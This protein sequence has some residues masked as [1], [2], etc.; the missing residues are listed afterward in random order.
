[1]GESQNVGNKETKQAKFSV[2]QT[3]L[4]PHT[5]TYVCVSGG[6]KCLLY[7]KFGLLCFLVTSIFRFA[8]LPY[9]RR[10]D[11]FTVSF[12]NNSKANQNKHTILLQLHQVQWTCI[13]TTRPKNMKKQES[14][15]TLYVFSYWIFNTQVW[16]VFRKFSANFCGEGE[17]YFVVNK[18]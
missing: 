8:L 5:H 7:G 2:K 18:S 1:M 17:S 10:F 4:T 11:V 16:Q 9:Y 6:K 15:I 13:P 14:E 3:F 12:I